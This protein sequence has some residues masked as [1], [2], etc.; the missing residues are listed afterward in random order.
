MRS[1]C[2]MDRKKTLNALDLKQAIACLLESDFRSGD[3]A[4]RAGVIF[5]IWFAPSFL[6]QSWFGVTVAV[7]FGLTMPKLFLLARFRA[8]DSML[9]IEYSTQ[10]EKCG[11][12][13]RPVQKP[14][15]RFSGMA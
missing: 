7:R 14:V 9:Q 4:A 11:R 1:D 8:S 2:D 13:I 15:N 3:R 6:F 12:V 10:P 5:S